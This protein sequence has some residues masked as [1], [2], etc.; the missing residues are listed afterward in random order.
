MAMLE[1]ALLGA[2]IVGMGISAY[3]SYREGQDAAEASRY[4]A[5]MSRLSSER[6]AQMV[7]ASGALDASRQRKATRTLVGKQK[8]L[9]G[10][11]GVELTGSPLDVMINTAAEGE[12]DAQILEYNTKVKAQ[13]LRY[14]G[15]AQAAYDEKMAGIY[16]TSGAYKAGS[17]LLTSGT[18]LAS[19][20]YKKPTKTETGY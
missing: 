12:L 2:G 19:T 15:S 4:N 9:Y 7:E 10:A 16:E 6:E 13:T 14:G 8:A 5:E 1:A 11:S 17:T 18:Q 20:Y 3:G